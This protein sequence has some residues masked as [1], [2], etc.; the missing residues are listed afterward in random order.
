[1]EISDD[2]GFNDGNFMTEDDHTLLSYGIKPWDPEAD[3]VLEALE[4]DRR[5]A[6]RQNAKRKQSY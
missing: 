5:E 1:M 6:L 2:D 3:A 4:R